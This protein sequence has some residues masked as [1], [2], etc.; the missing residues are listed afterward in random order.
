[1]KIL[2]SDEEIMKVYVNADDDICLE[3]EG[4]GIVFTLTPIEAQTLRDALSN[5][6]MKTSYFKGFKKNG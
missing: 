4:Y 2:D 5:L 6:L 1:M 3:S